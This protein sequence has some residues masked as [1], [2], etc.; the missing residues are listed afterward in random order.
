MLL[1][2]IETSAS[3]PREDMCNG[4]GVVPLTRGRW[5]AMDRQG[6]RIPP[7]ST[8]RWLGPAGKAKIDQPADIR[9][10]CCTVGGAAASADCATLIATAI[11]GPSQA[12]ARIIWNVGAPFSDPSSARLTRG[13]RG[14]F[15]PSSGTRR[16]SR[17]V[18]AGNK[19]DR[20]VSVKDQAQLRI[21]RDLRRRKPSTLRRMSCCQSR[22]SRRYRCRKES[23][24]RSVILREAPTMST[25]AEE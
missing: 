9:Q 18:P 7:P 5:F 24:S 10:G 17:Q 23:V 2:E 16:I 14:L 21:L 4:V 22:S 19:G 3:A 8:P 13:L 12:C 15:A 25:Q 11:S 20:G 1:A 6:C